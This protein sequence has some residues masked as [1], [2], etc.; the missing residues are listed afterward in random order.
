[1]R[2]K[3][4]FNGLID[5]GGKFLTV[6]LPVLYATYKFMAYD[7]GDNSMRISFIFMAM[8]AIYFF[9]RIYADRDYMKHSQVFALVAVI[10][11]CL[12]LVANFTA[13][14]FAGFETEIESQSFWLHDILEKL[15]WLDMTSIYLYMVHV[16]VI[17]AEMIWAIPIDFQDSSVTSGGRSHDDTYASN[18]NS[19][20]RIILPD[21]I[22]F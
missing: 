19:L 16:I 6:L 22:R 2:I 8:G 21:N 12:G 18:I 5:G 7:K 3:P 4:V 1:M 13:A 9:L 17:F 11:L 15:K 20:V 10:T 14:I